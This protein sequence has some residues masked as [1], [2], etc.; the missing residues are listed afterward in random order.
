MNDLTLTVGG[1]AATD[2]KLHVGA[3][4]AAMC[5][6]RLAST[7]RRFDR[8]AG[9]WVDGST[10]W[11]TVRVFRAGAVT[12]HESVRKGQ[13]L[14]VTGR[15]RTNV[16]EAADG[17]RT[18]LQVDATAVG[19]DLTRGIATFTRAVGDAALGGEATP[20]TTASVGQADDTERETD[21]LAPS[22]AELDA[23]SQD[24]DGE[25]DPWETETMDDSS[26]A[27]DERVTS[28]V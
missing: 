22:G 9:E 3:G 18:D 28:A 6:F 15:L 13:P 1:W 25:S 4:G 21:A 7:P 11:F 16:W 2:P 5:T 19:H 27:V 24:A 12:V 10:E 26:E 23:D 14:M 20:G 8:G 17:P